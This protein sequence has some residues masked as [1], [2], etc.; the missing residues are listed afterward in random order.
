MRFFLRRAVNRCF[1]AFQTEMTLKFAQLCPHN[2]GRLH[3][4]CHKWPCIIVL[5]KLDHF[6]KSTLHL[7]KFGIACRACQLQIVLLGS[8]GQVA[9]PNLDILNPQGQPVL[10]VLTDWLWFAAPGA[11]E[12]RA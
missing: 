6:L 7:H 11:V 1:C 8:Q 5:P 9:P 2:L 10:S 12:Y 4:S 3:Q